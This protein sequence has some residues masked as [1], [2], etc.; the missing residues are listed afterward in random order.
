MFS[1]LKGS[2]RPLSIV[3]SYY[4][5]VISYKNYTF[6]IEK[7]ITLFD[8][9]SKAQHRHV[10]N[11]VFKCVEIGNKTLWFNTQPAYSLEVPT[12]HPQL[13]PVIRAKLAALSLRF[14]FTHPPTLNKKQN[15]LNVGL[16]MVN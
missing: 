9:F 16:Q 10:T 12:D 7:S 1:V 8:E 13:S 11:S 6:L 3:E 15:F 4:K 14:G 2:T 5:N